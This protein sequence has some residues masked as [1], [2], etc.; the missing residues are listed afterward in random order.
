MPLICSPVGLLDVSQEGLQL[1]F[2]ELSCFLSVT[3]CA[4]ALY[5]LGIQGVE[6]LIPLGAFFSANFGSSI[7]VKFLIYR[8]QA[9]CFCILVT[10][11]DPTL[12]DQFYNFAVAIS[13]CLTIQLSLLF[14]P[15]LTHFSI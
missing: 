7:S 13:V 3:W 12:P 15:L 4:E 9:I 14:S 5:G 11:L 6:S 10:I 2:G 8:D 1:A